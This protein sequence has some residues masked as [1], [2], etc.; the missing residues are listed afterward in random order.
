MDLVR[1]LHTQG[2]GAEVSSPGELKVALESGIP[3]ER[4]LY[5]GPAKS[6]REIASS[7][8]AGISHFSV[9]SIRDFRRIEESARTLGTKAHVLLRINPDEPMAGSGLSMGGT[10][11]QFGIDP[12]AIADNPQAFASSPWIDVLG[13]H[14]YAGTNLLTTGALL[15]GFSEAVRVAVQLSEVLGIRPRAI[16]LGGGF[17]HPFASTGDRPDFTQLRAPLEKLLDDQLHGWRDSDP[18]ILFESGRYLSASCGSLVCRVEDVKVSKSHAF[19]V[20]DSGIH[21]LG[22]MSGLRRVPR[23]VP[24]LIPVGGPPESG[25]TSLENADIVGSLCTPLDCWGR[26]VQAPQVQSG[27]YLRVPNVGAYG[28]TAS[29]LGFLSRDCPLEIVLD[30]GKV[31]DVSRL[32]LSRRPEPT[33]SEI[34]HER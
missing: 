13:F 10:G 21:H 7:L 27:D 26:N 2:C 3:P 32:I 33:L 28:L 29:L 18:Q 17:G 25:T 12:R 23:I 14:I 22:G 31:R 19:V 15:G 11:T 34:Q 30:R 5:T 1:E 16:D 8:G 6:S 9:E 4:C 24:D 20:L